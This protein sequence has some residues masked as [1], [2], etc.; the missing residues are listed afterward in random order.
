MTFF[1]HSLCHPFVRTKVWRPKS[2]WGSLTIAAFHRVPAS[3]Y[4]H[5]QSPFLPLPINV[6][7]RYLLLVQSDPPMFLLVFYFL[8]AKFQELKTNINKN[9]AGQEL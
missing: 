7:L 5:P 4:A 2:A 6:L 9:I 8:N 3:Y 1:F